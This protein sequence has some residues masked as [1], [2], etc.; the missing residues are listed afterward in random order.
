M[1]CL[2]CDRAAA[3]HG[4]LLDRGGGSP[5]ALCRGCLDYLRAVR[6]SLCG[7]H[8]GAWS[9]RRDG[10]VCVESD[11][12]RAAIPVCPE[13]RHNLLDVAYGDVPVVTNA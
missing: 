6:C 1:T 7:E 11:D 2:L 12:D 8:K 13:C 9:S 4:S 3:Y 5:V 10:E